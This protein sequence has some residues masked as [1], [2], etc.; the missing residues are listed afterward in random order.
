MTDFQQPHEP[1]P[2]DDGAPTPPQEPPS[3][4][5][6]LGEPSRLHR[7]GGTAIALVTVVAALLLTVLDQGPIA[8]FNDLQSKILGGEYYPL[9]TFLLVWMALLLPLAAL[10][11]LIIRLIDGKDAAKR[12]VQRGTRT[13]RQ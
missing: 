12:A 11:L 6:K 4:Q 2:A 10:W 8:W 7:T 9:L 5:S 13:L 3:Q 1:S